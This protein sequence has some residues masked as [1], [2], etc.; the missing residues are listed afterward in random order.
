MARKEDV[1]DIVQ[2]FVD[3]DLASL[4]RIGGVSDSYS[5][6]PLLGETSPML[7]SPPERL[8]CKTVLQEGDPSSISYGFGASETLPDGTLQEGDGHSSTDNTIGN[9]PSTISSSNN[10]GSI[11]GNFKPRI[12]SSS[13]ANST[14]TIDQEKRASFGDK[15]KKFGK[16]ITSSSKK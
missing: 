1:Q 14:S 16:R 15:F 4:D 5:L 7:T 2:S 9:H 11:S 13:S 3:N 6:S 10:R 8:S 12:V